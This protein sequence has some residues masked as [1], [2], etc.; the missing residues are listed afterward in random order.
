MAIRINVTAVRDCPPV[1]VRAVR[2]EVIRLAC[3]GPDCTP[4]GDQLDVHEHGGWTWFAT[5]VWVVSPGDL[6]RGLCKLARPALQ[7]STSDGDR[8][9]LTV[10]G[11]THGQVHFLHEF[12]CHSHTPDPAEDAERQAQLDRPEEPPPVDP[13]LAFLEEDRPTGPDRPKAPFDL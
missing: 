3:A 8:W 6:N 4:V 5:S 10:H 13:R 7:F 12:S 1:E 11:G 9:F 2:S